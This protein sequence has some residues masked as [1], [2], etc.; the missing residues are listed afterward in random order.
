[1]TILHSIIL[2]VVEGL[3]EFLPISST[4]HLIIAS[5]ILNI[6][7][8]EFVKSFEIFIQLGAIMAVFFIYIKKILS[9]KSIILNLIYAFIP[10][11]ILGFIFYKQVKFILGNALIV[12]VAL[13]LGG[14][15]ILLIERHLAQK[16]VLENKLINKKE[17]FLLGII[18]TLAFIPGVSRSGALIM[19]GLL[20][21]ISRVE[22]VEF[23]FLLALPTMAAATGYDMLKT[24][25]AFNTNQWL[26]LAIGFITAFITAFFAIKTFLKFVQ[27]HTF[28]VFG[29]YRIIAGL[30]FLI[31]LI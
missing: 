1:M 14:I 17:S 19:G 30:I 28:K 29:W 16:I 4:G 31:I 21:K 13:I 15:I 7:Q 26:L 8:T 23:S 18:Q 3:T 22:I 27:N 5:Q 12:P 25:F 24:G 11:A 20:R 9:N 6:T 10:T 2:G